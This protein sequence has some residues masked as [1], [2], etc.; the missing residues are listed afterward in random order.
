MV[1]FFFLLP[2]PRQE[3][4]VI[5]ESQQDPS[6]LRSEQNAMKQGERVSGWAGYVL[7]SLVDTVLAGIQEGVQALIS[8]PSF[9]YSPKY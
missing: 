9:L 7:F 2:E 5:H 4:G 3:G 6:W 8:A 1:F